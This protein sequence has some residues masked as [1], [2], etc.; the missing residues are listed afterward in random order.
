MDPLLLWRMELI[1]FCSLNMTDFWNIS[2]VE[3]FQNYKT[4][5]GLC[6]KD[7]NKNIRPRLGRARSSSKGAYVLG[8]AETTYRTVVAIL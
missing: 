3:L 6:P 8:E 1:W 5:D 4:P 7:P 2:G